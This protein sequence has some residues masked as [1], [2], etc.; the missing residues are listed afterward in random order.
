MRCYD[1]K[2][3]VEI[4]MCDENNKPIDAENFLGGGLPF[5]SEFGAYRVENVDLCRRR[6]L[7][8][9]DGEGDFQSDKENFNISG[10][11]FTYVFVESIAELAEHFPWNDV[12]IME[13]ENDFKMMSGAIFF[14]SFQQLLIEI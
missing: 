8:W 3:I 6:V 9:V 2:K 14:Q 10:R 1:K 4:Y 5:N 13:T 11:E 7:D 12:V